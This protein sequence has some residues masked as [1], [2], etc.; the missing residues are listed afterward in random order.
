[1]GRLD[2]VKYAAADI[3]LTQLCYEELMGYTTDFTGRFNLDKPLTEAH[4]AYI[5]AFGDTRR[6]TR[7]AKITAARPDPLRE[8]VGLPVGD[9]GG[10]YV[11][12]GGFAGQGD[13]GFGTDEKAEAGITEYNSA[14]TGQPG[15]WCQWAPSEDRNHIEWDGSEKFYHYVEWLNYLIENFLKP[16]GYKISGE[17][18]YQGEEQ[19]DNGRLVIVAGIC[20]TNPGP[21]VQLADCAGDLT[22]DSFEA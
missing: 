13:F 14:P 15:L 10:F 2:R 17:V 20:K 18:L 7:D 6:M 5:K 16:W 12:E 4:A 11:G 3:K 21:L 9:E 1:M 22:N 19:S 8:A